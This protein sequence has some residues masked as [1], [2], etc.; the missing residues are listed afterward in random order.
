M[1]FGLLSS[2]QS[3]FYGESGSVFHN[4]NNINNID[5]ATMSFGQGITITPL[6]LITAVS[7]IANEGTL[8]Q[9]RIV[10]KIVDPSTNAITT[11]PVT[12]VRQVVSKQTATQMMEMLDY[13]VSDGT[14]M[15]ADVTGYSI[16]GKSGTSENLASSDN[17][18]VA[19][20]IG[21]SPTVN[22]QV[23]VLV[24]LYN[25]KGDSFQ[26][27][28]I[29]GPVVSQIFSELLPYLGIASTSISDTETD[30]T[31]TI[32]KDVKGKTIREAKQLL[33]TDGFT[34]HLNS[35]ED[36]NT[37]ITNQM[38]KPGV[39]LVDGA[40]IFLYTE[41]S[42]VATS[43]TVPNFKNKAFEQCIN[44]AQEANLNIVAEG[45][46]IVVSQDVPANTEVEIGSVI[47]LTLKSELE[48]GY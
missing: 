2:T 48:G 16:G 20:F 5:L 8:V 23:V 10:D 38:P 34:V 15:H 45:S 46:G 47:S 1:P 31:T 18:Y 37:L 4:K 29:A 42:N 9:P 40:D 3:S 6:Q 36:E 28:T 27:G 41:S 13:A 30:Y 25:P 43:V 7:S 22:T 14:G 44:M 26:G 33:E 21:L 32:L 35:E 11:T 19:S 39:N 24:A 17:T 12:E